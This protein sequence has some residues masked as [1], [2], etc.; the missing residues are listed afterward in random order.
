M[1][2]IHLSPTTPWITAAGWT[3]IHSMWQL[4]LFAAIY[5]VAQSVLKSY[6]GKKS[7]TLLYGLGCTILL[8]MILAP[9]VTFGYNL[10]QSSDSIAPQTAMAS[11][12]LRASWHQESILGAA[13]KASKIYPDSG[14]VNDPTHLGAV[15]AQG[16]I[17]GCSTLFYW[18]VLTW[19]IGVCL[20][21]LRP[22]LG[23]LHV[24]RLARSGEIS[25]NPSWKRS[26]H[27]LAKSMGIKVVIR[28][29]ESTRVQVPT[30]AGYWRPIVLL[31]AFAATGLT[32]QELQLILGHELAH[33]RR[34][35]YLV[36]F[37]QTMIETVLFYHP[38]TWWLSNQIRIER[39]HCCDD[40][41]VQYGGNPTTLAKA[42]LAMEESRVIAPTLAANGG[43]L[44][45]RVQRLLEVPAAKS[46]PT[47][48]LSG[49]GLACL[50]LLV[51]VS[52]ALG[53]SPTTQETAVFPRETRERDPQADAEDFHAIDPVL[54][55]FVIEHVLN[56][57]CQNLGIEISPTQIDQHIQTLAGNAGLQLNEYIA[58]FGCSEKFLRSLS[59]RDLAIQKV[60]ESRTGK[61]LSPR[62]PTYP[63][64]V[65]QLLAEIPEKVE[66]RIIDF[67]KREVLRNKDTYATIDDHPVSIGQYRSLI[68]DMANYGDWI[69]R[70]DAV[71]QASS[72]IMVLAQS[73]PQ[74]NILVFYG[75]QKRD[76]INFWRQVKDD[77]NRQ[78]F[79][80]SAKEYVEN[81]QVQASLEERTLA[82]TPREKSPLEKAALEL[83]EGEISAVI[84]IDDRWAVLHRPMPSTPPQEVDERE[85]TYAYRVADLVVSPHPFVTN[86]SGNEEKKVDAE[87]L[88]E[89]IKR[90]VEPDSWEQH[91]IVF[92]EDH[93][94]FAIS[95]QR[96]VHEQIADLLEKLRELNEVTIETTAFLVVLSE[97]DFIHV[98][99]SV[100]K[101]PI[102]IDRHT[103]A[104]LNSFAQVKESAQIQDFPNTI[105]HNGQ[106]N[107]IEIDPID[108]SKKLSLTIQQTINQDCS[109]VRTVFM[110]TLPGNGI[111]L[112]STSG[113]FMAV[114]LSPMLSLDPSAQRAVLVF[115]STIIRD[116]E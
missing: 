54:D 83:G 35:D 110:E 42:L 59:W 67:Q 25:P 57:E 38:A 5:A 97:P 49:M 26:A 43:T 16:Q 61:T 101:E 107:T 74:K 104:S 24:Q 2:W 48:G 99:D 96:Y 10:Y 22:A 20:F 81:G 13:N 79:E 44:L 28:F 63:G 14:L 92:F 15:P 66:V 77:P 115:K 1:D 114:D 40:T 51:S 108:D 100:D 56:E 32:P 34:Q 111:Q 95:H 73:T 23:I 8:A 36:N 80:K 17:N 18:I 105:L 84:Q 70:Q 93:L 89:L 113:Q 30:I 87:P 112:S 53:S 37:V 88:L 29:V 98:P 19:F 27:Q 50:L 109:S 52:I 116:P 3:I 103:A 76:A 65:C 86:L 31:P 41:A 7:S 78:S 75:A 60:L 62:E 69:V 33:I 55:A 45:S 6:L 85:L 11:V 58:Q 21:A 90:T 68:R 82:I 71:T 4:T 12:S 64:E 47:L 94:S 91:R 102:K 9:A 39:E 72:R 106:S 46:S